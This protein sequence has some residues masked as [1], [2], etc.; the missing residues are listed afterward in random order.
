M[1]E[2]RVQVPKMMRE[3]AEAGRCASEGREG[4][5]CGAGRGGDGVNRKP[6][7]F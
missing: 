6:M 4:N 2:K 3:G 1:R 5:G 7:R